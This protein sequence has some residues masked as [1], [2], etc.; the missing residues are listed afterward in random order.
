MYERILAYF[1]STPWAVM[2]Q[3]LEVMGDMIAFRAGGGTLTK[4][5]IRARI[6]AAEERQGVGRVLTGGV[7]VIPLVGIITPRADMLQESSGFASLEKFRARFR[8]AL[9]SEQVASI[10]IA[11]TVPSW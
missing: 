3:T 9:A 7:A 11:D 6:D 2:P 10:L 4:E 1:N 8:E 5:E